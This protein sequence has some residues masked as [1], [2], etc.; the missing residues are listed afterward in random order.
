MPHSQNLYCRFDPPLCPSSLAETV[1]AN[2]DV[3][4]LGDDH[5]CVDLHAPGVMFRCTCSQLMS[6]D[7]TTA[8][9][10]A[11]YTQH[12]HIAR[13]LADSYATVAAAAIADAGAG[14][15][16]YAGAPG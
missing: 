7:A 1:L 6:V 10:T 13:E 14:A 15:P 16:L 8:V 3:L 9:L 4:A 12:I 5:L 2:A 11:Y